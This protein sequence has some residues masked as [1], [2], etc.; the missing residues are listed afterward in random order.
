[1]DIECGYSPH[2]NVDVNELISDALSTDDFDTPEVTYL[3][4]DRRLAAP[5]TKEQGVRLLNG[6]LSLIGK[7]S[8]L[9]THDSDLYKLQVE[10]NER[11]N[12]GLNALR[13]GRG[14][15]DWYVRAAD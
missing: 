14:Q 3:D 13:K 5:I 7:T 2:S 10:Y 1:M 12:F 8:T 9:I 11:D 15:S 6:L 4:M